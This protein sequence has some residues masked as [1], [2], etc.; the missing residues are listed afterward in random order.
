MSGV[1]TAVLYYRVSTEEQGKR[2]YSLPEQRRECRAKA[3]ALASQQRARL[4]VYEFEDTASGEVLE[5]PGLEAC[6]AFLRNKDTQAQYFVCLDPDRFARGLFLQLLVT[7]EIEKAGVKLVF[8]QHDYQ[9]TAE[10]RLFYQMRGAISEFEKAKIKE[11]TAR[12]R[13]G[14]LAVGAIPNKV[15]PWGYTWDKQTKT[16]RIDPNSAPWVQQV[17][18][19]YLDGWSYFRIVQKLEELGVPAPGGTTWYRRTIQRVLQNSVYVGRLVVNRWDAA[20]RTPLRKVP[21]DK[22]PVLTPK[23]KDEAEWVTIEVPALISEE[24]WNRVRAQHQN[25]TRLSQPGVGMLSGVCICGL[26]GSNMHYAG[27]ADRRYL[28]CIGRYPHFRDGSQRV[29]KLPACT[30]SNL[31]AD[32]FEREIWSQVKGWLKDPLELQK[33]HEAQRTKQA[34]APVDTSRIRVIEAQ[35]AERQEEHRR[36]FRL[37]VKGLAPAGTEEELERLAAQV[38]ALERELAALT[39]EQDEAEPFSIDSLADLFALAKQIGDE[40]DSLDLEGRQRVVR[41]LLKAITIYP[42]HTWAPAFK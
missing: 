9:N 24:D 40:L 19:W 12:G 26:C 10:G 32:R 16:L 39:P 23:L 42:D 38:K 3:E 28:R 36:M 33:A 20:G 2:G 21:R 15:E 5:R 7:E 27:T 22:R 35:L 37:V 8:V 34:T 13:R 14:K 4:E 17:F 6:R 31:R 1:V 25:R 18:Q 30:L 29:N 41:S 11:R